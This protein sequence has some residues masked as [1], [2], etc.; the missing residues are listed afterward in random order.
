MAKVEKSYWIDCYQGTVGEPIE[1][2]NIYA[3]LLTA[4]GEVSHLGIKTVNG[5]LIEVYIHSVTDAYIIGEI[6]RYRD[7]F[8]T[9]ANT[10]SK[11]EKELELSKDES[12]IE[13][14]QF[15]LYKDHNVLLFQLKKEA[16][17]ATQLGKYLQNLLGN[18]LVVFYKVLS[19]GAYERLMSGKKLFKN[20]EYT[21]QRPHNLDS[22]RRDDSWTDGI[23][24]HFAADSNINTLSVRISIGQEGTRNNAFLSCFQAVQAVMGLNPSKAKVASEDNEIIDLVAERIRTR[25]SIK[26]DSLGDYRGQIHQKIKQFG[27][28]IAPEIDMLFRHEQ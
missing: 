23:L 24:N 2:R 5:H 11:T 13:Y 3:E 10:A 14:N 1:N 4:K 26:A 19:Q 9:I 12:L 8:L 27:E 6:R 28:H 17:N 15:I 25:V 18:D 20:F 7:D 16:C 22:Y 21:V